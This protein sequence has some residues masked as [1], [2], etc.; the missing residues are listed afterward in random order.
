MIYIDDV[1]LERPLAILHS[2][3]VPEDKV[4][5]A[6]DCCRAFHMRMAEAKLLLY[7]AIQPNGSTPAAKKVESDLDLSRRSIF[8]A[9]QALIEDGL[10]SVNDIKR[11]IFVDW[12]TIITA[13]MQYAVGESHN[14]PKQR[15]KGLFS[16]KQKFNPWAFLVMSPQEEAD[17]FYR[18]SHNDYLKVRQL[19]APTFPK[20]SLDDLLQR[21]D[22]VEWFGKTKEQMNDWISTMSTQEI[23]ELKETCYYAL[24]YDGD[25]GNP[26]VDVHD[27]VDRFEP[28]GCWKFNQNDF[29]NI[30]TGKSDES[31]ISEF[32]LDDNLPF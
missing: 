8:Y 23:A 19:I 3:K 14:I 31:D 20:A 16:V 6:T 21:L 5:T 7:Y 11:V 25:H 4:K 18:M 26:I 12:T 13:A 9:R 28:S 10:I 2:G 27:I 29:G 17:W 22:T 15:R 32:I 30:K 24:G 1:Y